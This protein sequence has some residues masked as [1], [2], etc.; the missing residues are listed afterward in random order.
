M[1][2][3]SYRYPEKIEDIQIGDKYQV[4]D[5]SL[6]EWSA[7]KVLSHLCYSTKVYLQCLINRKGIRILND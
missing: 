7:T 4:K 1:K 5:L 2:M 6:L 3:N